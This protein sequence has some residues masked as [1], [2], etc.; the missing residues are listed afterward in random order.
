MAKILKN[1]AVLVAI[2]LVFSAAILGL[3]HVASPI[4]DANEAARAT[5]ALAVVLPGGTTFEALDMATLSDVPATVTAI[6]KESAGKGYVVELSTTSQFSEGPLKILMGVD[7]TGAIAGINIAEEHETKKMPEAFVPS[8]VGQNSTLATLDMTLAAG[9]TYTATA[10]KNAVADGFAALNANG[11]VA[12]AKKSDAQVLKEL[13]PTV[14][15]GL[16]KSGNLDVTELAVSGNI[17]LALKANSGVGFAYIM[18]NGESSVLVL[19][20]NGLATKVYGVDGAETSAP[21]ALV[22]EAV[23]HAKANLTQVDTAKFS[24]MMEG[25][26]VADGKMDGVYSTVAGVYDITA[27]GKNY[28]GI[29]SKLTGFEAMTVYYILDET[30]AIAAMDAD[31]FIF[32]ESDF[33]EYGGFDGLNRKEYKNGFA[34]MTKDTVSD[35]AILIA[36]ATMTSN[37]MKTATADIFAAFETVKGGAE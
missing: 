3:N 12:E 19:V 1:T 8:F 9:T 22:Q 15:S 21:D 5:G 37:A 13:A 14:F 4:I 17:E 32:L 34:G 11:L 27:G 29:I 24:T 18:K 35:D 25:A 2:A 7:A 30:G 31:E 26:T 36:K 33:V 6:H 10:F 16:A 23:D 20:N 28:T